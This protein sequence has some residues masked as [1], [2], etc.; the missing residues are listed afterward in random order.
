[1]SDTELSFKTCGRLDNPPADEDEAVL[2]WIVLP[3]WVPDLIENLPGALVVFVF[4]GPDVE[5]WRFDGANGW[6][7]PI[8]VLVRSVSRYGTEP[9]A[10]LVAWMEV[11]GKDRKSVRIR[12][13]AE[14]GQ[15]VPSR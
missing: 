12:V 5:Y 13:T 4:R 3:K 6:P 1:M 8:D 7:A 14:H 15:R 10:V 9:A 2:T 11:F